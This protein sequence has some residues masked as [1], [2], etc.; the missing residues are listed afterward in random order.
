MYCTTH[1]MTLL[2]YR[3]RMILYKTTRLF[4]SK[5]NKQ[6]PDRIKFHPIGQAVFNSKEKYSEINVEFL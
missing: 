6:R 1:P 2:L 5:M 4:Y 3:G